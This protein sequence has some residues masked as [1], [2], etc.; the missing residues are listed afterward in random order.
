LVIAAVYIGAIYGTE[1]KSG[2]TKAMEEAVSDTQIAGE[3]AE[4]QT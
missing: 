4:P 2:G 1:Q 3:V